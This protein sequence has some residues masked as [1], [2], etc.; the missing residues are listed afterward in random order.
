MTAVASWADLVTLVTMPGPA[1]LD[2]VR[3]VRKE[4]GSQIGALIVAEMSSKGNKVL[5]SQ[6]YI[7]PRVSAENFQ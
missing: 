2:A 4:T 6:S 5:G 3:L 7:R 1:I